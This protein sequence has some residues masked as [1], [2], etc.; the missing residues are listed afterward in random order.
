MQDLEAALKAPSSLP[1]D[2]QLLAKNVLDG[3]RMELSDDKT[4][5]ST[6]AK[7]GQVE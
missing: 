2:M 6:F 1:V 3:Y 7:K 5:L 4:D